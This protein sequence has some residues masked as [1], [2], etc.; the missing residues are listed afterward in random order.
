MA[1]KASPQLKSS[2]L[3]KILRRT[4]KVPELRRVSSKRPFRQSEE[5][6]TFR[7]EAHDP[8]EDPEAEGQANLRYVLVHVKDLTKIYGYRICPCTSRTQLFKGLG[9]NLVP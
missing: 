6:S 2:E 9:L 8:P 5:K 1:L 7:V 4:T 3:I